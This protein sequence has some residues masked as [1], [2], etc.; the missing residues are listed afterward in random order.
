MPNENVLF[1]TDNI[2]AIR[3]TPTRD[4]KQWISSLDL[5][6]NSKKTRIDKAT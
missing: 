4:V 3:G 6:K 5:M 1:A 2:Y